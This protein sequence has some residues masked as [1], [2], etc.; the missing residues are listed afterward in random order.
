M[1]IGVIADTH[2]LLRPEVLELFRDVSLIIHAGD[3][4]TPDVLDTLREVAPVHA[5][6]G[7]VD[8]GAWGTSL[9][10]TEVVECN[11]IF[12][13]LLH[14]VNTLDLD[15]VAAGMQVVISGH[16]HRP[17][18]AR[19]NSVLYLN[20]GSAG[21]RRFKLPITAAL[22]RIDESGAISWKII[23]LERRTDHENFDGTDVTR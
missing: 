2:G 9:P 21:P 23:E 14:D 5:V 22:L 8:K 17:G 13:Y 10:Q 20:P 7:N 4:G 3:I 12:I 6:R 18:E 11:G 1:M 15:P 19:K 16:S